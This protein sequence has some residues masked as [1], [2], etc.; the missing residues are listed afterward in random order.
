M[1]HTVIVECTS[2]SVTKCGEGLVG[3]RPAARAQSYLAPPHPWIKGRAHRKA[4]APTTHT[5]GRQKPS[6]EDEILLKQTNELS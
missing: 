5:L 2:P 6:S 3:W 4:E 1:L